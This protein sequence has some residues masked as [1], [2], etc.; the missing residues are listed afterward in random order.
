MKE[1]QHINYS[2]YESW[3]L[4]FVDL[5]LS[6][7][8]KQQ[9]MKFVEDNPQLKPELDALLATKNVFDEGVSFNKKE[10]IFKKAPESQITDEQLILFLDGE[11][12]MA[13]AEK[14]R[15][16]RS[17]TLRE[18]LGQL[19][20]AYSIA[21]TSITYPKKE[22]LYKRGRVAVLNYWFARAA[23]AII[24]FAIGFW[25]FDN[26]RINNVNDELGSISELDR[27]INDS[28]AMMPDTS[29]SSVDFPK[30]ADEGAKNNR[31]AGNNNTASAVDQD[32]RLVKNTIEVRPNAPLLPEKKIPAFPEPTDLKMEKQSDALSKTEITSINPQKA[33][34][35]PV[36][37]L[38]EQLKPTIQ[39]VAASQP[40]PER[41]RKSFFKNVTEKFK[42][43]AIDFLSDDN[44]NINV[45]G[46]AINV[47]K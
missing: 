38:S 31:L 29:S 40:E 41:K 17:E 24:V 36:A 2:N 6:E 8:Q 12:D 18:R 42:E 10:N 45:A 25:L 9:V 47:R 44:E 39:V 32:T 34:A 11:L 3:F 19:K 26:Y 28:S 33:G 13:A 46:F 4:F 43:R 7:D 37:G 5:E 21:D 14:I 16:D 22:T 23:A 35:E 30:R 15:E 1:N 20:S 27:T